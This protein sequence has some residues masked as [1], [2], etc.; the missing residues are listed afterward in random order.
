MMSNES[1]VVAVD[2]NTENVSFVDDFDEGSEVTPEGCYNF[3]SAQLAFI[4]A[5]NF[6]VEGVFLFLVASVGFVANLISIVILRR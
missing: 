3:S 2:E 6:W 5:N 1:V 4:E